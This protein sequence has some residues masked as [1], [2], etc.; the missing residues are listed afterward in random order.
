MLTSDERDAVCG[1]VADFATRLL[2]AA[3]IDEKSMHQE[4]DIFFEF[5]CEALEIARRDGVVRVRESIGAS[6]N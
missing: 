2:T 5:F 1:C 3:T 4:L 6:N